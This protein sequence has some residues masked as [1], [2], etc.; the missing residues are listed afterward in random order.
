MAENNCTCAQ[1]GDVIIP[2][3]NKTTGLP[4]KAKRKFCSPKCGE[5]FH[6]G[7]RSRYVRRPHRPK[8]VECEHCK[9]VVQR[10]VSGGGR[11]AGRYCSRDCAF[12]AAAEQSQRNHDE[13]LAK[14]VV[15]RR[16]RREVQ[17]LRRI[18]AYVE[19]PAVFRFG[20]IHCGTEMIVRRRLG[21]HRQVCDECTHE[22]KVR[23]RKEYRAR[24]A[25]RGLRAGSHRSRARRFGVEFDPTVSS[26]RVFERDGWRCR[27]CGTK[28][29]QRLR[30]T[31]KDNA[32]ELDHVVPLS[33]GGGHTWSNVQCA[34]RK[35]NIEK[36]ARAL[37]QIGL[38]FDV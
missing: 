38:G 32:P 33:I 35:C 21:L 34:C 8:T 23:L 11:D 19:R 16:V 37:G 30:G 26:I 22:T 20:C 28:T 1:C 29:P 24:L 4:S 17:S 15:K 5:R 13:R 31:F 18:A 10:R 12:A 14:L 25:E 9:K 6:S 7:D 36:G 2:R 3:I 27:I